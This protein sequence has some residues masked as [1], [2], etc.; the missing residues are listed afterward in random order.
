MYSMNRKKGFALACVFTFLF[1]LLLALVKTADVAAIGPEG[2]EIGLS[3]LNAAVRDALGFH[4][5]WYRITQALGGF[6]IVV[7]A[8]F[9]LVGLTQL[10]RRKSFWRVDREIGA[11]G[12]LYAFV[13]VLYVAFEVVIVNYRPVIMPGE[14]HVEASF[15]SSHTMLVCVVMGSAMLLARR[16]FA[17]RGDGVKRAAAEA[18]C[19]LVIA[20]TVF[21]RLYAGVHWLTD[22][23]AGVLLSAARLS[24][25]A[26]FIGKPGWGRGRVRGTSAPRKEGGRP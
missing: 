20:L 10:V 1:A 17:V 7:A 4:P 13:V 19:A 26:G 5:L 2:T 24:L 23:L 8:A 16:Y 22:I 9:A 6:A 21:G 18:L 12:F 14:E 25:S 3:R 11:L 15:P